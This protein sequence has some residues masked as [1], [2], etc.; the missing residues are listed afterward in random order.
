MF[1]SPKITRPVPIVCFAALSIFFSGCSDTSDI[2]TVVNE[3]HTALL[4]SSQE[5]RDAVKSVI[6]DQYL[7][8]QKLQSADTI[9]QAFS[10]DSVML[11]STQDQ[12]NNYRLERSLDMHDLVGEWARQSSPDMD[13]SKF[14]ILSLDI[15][16]ERIAVVT[17]KVQERVF[18]ALTLVKEGDE[19]KIASKVYI[20]QKD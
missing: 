17:L 19:W 20:L 8:G 7:K 15:V 18:D 2:N 5:T 16:D 1:I 14:E 3:N 10:P 9:R 6:F 4:A 12:E 11:F 13:L